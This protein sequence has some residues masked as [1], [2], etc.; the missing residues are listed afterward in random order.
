MGTLGRIVELRMKTVA[1]RVINKL[2]MRS[3]ICHLRHQLLEAVYELQ[4]LFEGGVF[5]AGAQV[6]DQIFRADPLLPWGCG[7]PF[8][9]SLRVFP[10]VTEYY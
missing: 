1:I 3:K 6:P 8:D 5:H 2:M 7:L 9:L 4:A 10:N